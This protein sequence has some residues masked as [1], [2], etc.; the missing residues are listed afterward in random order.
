MRCRAAALLQPYGDCDNPAVSLIIHQPALTPIVLR[1]RLLEV[2]VGVLHIAAAT[3]GEDVEHLAAQVV[4]FDEGVDDGRGG[5]PPNREAD[6]HGV[7]VGD[8]LALAFDGRT[9][10][11]VLHLDG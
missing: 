10:T 3:G 11:L 5:V 1:I 4:G 6:P 7:V 8:V 2:V 9:R